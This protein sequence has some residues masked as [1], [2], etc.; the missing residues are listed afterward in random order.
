MRPIKANLFFIMIMASSLALSTVFSQATAIKTN[1]DDNNILT[2]LVTVIQTEESNET[3]VSLSLSNPA[4][5]INGQVSVDVH[6]E[7]LDIPITAF[8]FDLRFDHNRLQL[9][10]AET[11]SF[12]DGAG[13]EVICPQRANTAEGIRFACVQSGEGTRASGSGK[14]VTLQFSGIA[15]GRTQISVANLKLV[16]SNT[17]PHFVEAAVDTTTLLVGIESFYIFLPHLSTQSVVERSMGETTS[18]IPAYHPPN[19]PS[20][21]RFAPETRAGT[22]TCYEIDFNC[23]TDI[24]TADL[25][26]IASVWNCT[27]GDACFISRYDLD[28]NRI[29]DARDLAWTSNEFDITPPEIKITTPV[30]NGILASNQVVITGTLSDTH[31]VVSV[32]A[33]DTPLTI[34]GQ[35]FTG[36]ITAPSGNQT[37]Y[38]VAT[39]EVGKMVTSELVIA[40][41]GAGPD[42]VISEPANRQA[43]YTLTPTV[44]LGYDDF[45]DD[46]DPGSLHVTVTDQNGHTADIT[47][48]IVA[49][50]TNAQG[51]VGFPLTADTIYT[52]TAVIA[53]TYGHDS[54]AT[55]TFYVPTDPENIIQPVETADSGYVSGQ[56]FASPECDDDLHGCASL[57]G[58]QVTLVRVTDMG[59]L[60]DLREMR[61]TAAISAN[62]QID[63]LATESNDAFTT[64]I[65]GTMITGPDGFF[66]FPVSET[67]HYWVFVEKDGY[68]DSQREVEIVR[69][70]SAT[71]YDVYLTPIDTVVTLCDT[72]G[73]EHTS[74][75]GRIKIDIPA[76]A[77]EPGDLLTTT[78]T[79][80]DQVEFLP[81]G[82][83]PPGTWETYAF[84][85]SGG[86]DQITFTRPVT[87]QIANTHGFDPGT[88]IPLGYWNEKTL[89]WEHA[90]TA[91]VDATGE[92][93]VM[94]VS[95][96]SKYDC[97]DPLAPPEDANAEGADES[98]DD[99]P[100]D[101]CSEASAEACII[102]LK[103]GHF[104]EEIELP[105]VTILGD[106]ETVKL[107][108]DTSS[109]MPSEVIDIKLSTDV[110]QNTTVGSHL[111]FELFIEGESIDQFTFEATLA[112]GEVGRY[113][114]LWDGTNSQGKQLPSG[115]Y[116]YQ[117]RFSIPY[118]SQ[119]CYALDGIFGNPPDCKDGATGRFI[120]GEDYVWV[121]GTVE[122]DV[123][124]GS[125]YGDGL[126]VKEM[127][128][129]YENEAGEILITNGLQKSEFYFPT[130]NILLESYT[131]VTAVIPTIEILD[132]PQD[133][134]SPQR[135]N[136]ATTT[137]CGELTSDTVWTKA[138]SPYLATCTIT[139]PLSTT[140]TIEPGVIVQFADLTTSLI[141]SGTLN[142]IGTANEMISFQPDTETTAGSWSQIRFIT[143]SV[144]V[145]DYSIVEYGGASQGSLW[146]GSHDVTVSN[147]IIQ[148][149]ANTGIYI[150][151]AHPTIANSEI[152]YNK[153]ITYGGGLLS[154]HGNPTIE[155]NHIHA[156]SAFR[157][158]GVY[159]NGA[160]DAILRNNI[161]FKNSV[162]GSTSRGGA[163]LITL[164]DGILIEGNRFEENWTSGSPSNGG[165]I[166]GT[167]NDES[168]LIIQNNHFESNAA[169]GSNRG[170]GGAISGHGIVLNNVFLNNTASRGAGAIHGGLML[171]EGNLFE[172][173]SSV[174]GGALYI[175]SSTIQ[176]NII[177]NN[178]AEVGGAIWT[179]RNNGLVMNNTIYNNQANSG[180]AIYMNYSD[181]PLFRNN[182]ITNNRGGRAFNGFAPSAGDVAYNNVWNNTGGN[183]GFSTPPLDISADPLF[184]D[185]ANGDFHLEDNSPMIDAGDPEYFPKT[186]WDDNL[187]YTGGAPDMGV[188]EF[189]NNYTPIS[190]TAADYSKLLWDS[191]SN[192]Y[193]RLY[194]DRTIVH[195]NTDGS[196]DY[197]L[198]PD[199][200]KTNYTY[201]SDGSV[202][203]IAITAPSETTPHWLWQF[204]Y[205]DGQLATITDPANRVT[206]FE[207]DRHN[208]LRSVAFPDQARQQF[209]YDQNGLMTHYIDE[210]GAITS[211]FFDDYG[212]I[213][214]VIEPARIVFDPT[215]GQ[216]QLN[217]RNL[218]FYPI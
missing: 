153:A 131:V 31:T 11:G 80:F 98:G 87:V 132:L 199:G 209:V 74:S 97:N 91:V 213:R 154:N 169:N 9:V 67:G 181:S 76:G 7:H 128:T 102:N 27:A 36:S 129:L 29:I 161:F 101:G 3:A 103:T 182:I 137:I 81:S 109:V 46:V 202:N 12:L 159:I 49:S 16:D 71:I 185:A 203:T 197:T 191:A 156:N 117:V 63:P 136:T 78:A 116:E 75:D 165:A 14:L 45:Y 66:S 195:F 28:G 177:V 211:H 123:Q 23:D 133:T 72:T 125:P 143:E 176:N 47:H 126:R 86:R 82:E 118:R 180:S 120:D 178:D 85:L 207:L 51:V 38:V 193:T 104:S 172:G 217:P 41:D 18:I 52:L 83:L 17:P 216:K 114:Y 2:P 57:S 42:I 54:I 119:Y 179:A 149:S 160:S 162:S 96:F 93:V 59:D 5:P 208:H 144:G 201:N 33:N 64:V 34:D 89:A 60:A 189:G 56:V 90:G 110:G 35:S 186:D 21:V 43:V 194:L 53:D 79:I 218:S 168:N 183:Y 204:T 88:E 58:A 37:L 205:A 196:H 188:D 214:Q 142:A 65:E 140:L 44:T 61:Q 30:H 124:Q 198:E 148:Y 174:L 175:G 22:G 135:T 150:E 100:E 15:D 210:E 84:D 108:Y 164:T 151:L 146:I 92:W 99:E 134:R 157:G 26:L 68:T 158:G 69:H 170:Y 48:N 155:S 10:S 107:I 192:T 200:R 127:Q 4:V 70:H 184:V 166:R 141:V 1:E 152:R 62:G 187:R 73:C 173:N 94:Q 95:H 55:S 163:V 167:D 171:V 6:L 13:H 39:D 115:I 8:Q 138:N 113:R 19:E 215:T 139:V 122:L 24:N 106:P 121:E 111:G 105:Y 25:S 212:R 145:L 190:R 206:T 147:S 77:I 20:K 50:E 32:A 40:I 130:K 112:N